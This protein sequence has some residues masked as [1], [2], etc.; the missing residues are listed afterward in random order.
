MLRN[1][2]GE[3]FAEREIGG[4]SVMRERVW[5]KSVLRERLKDHCPERKIGGKL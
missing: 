1:R 3:H 5:G 2:L 4:N